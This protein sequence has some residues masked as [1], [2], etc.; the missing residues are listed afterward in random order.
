MKSKFLYIL[1]IGSIIV[2]IYLQENNLISSSIGISYIALIV[3]LFSPFILY[4]NRLETNRPIVTV[5]LEEYNGGSLATPLNLKIYNMGNTPAIDVVLYS[6]KDDIDKILNNNINNELSDN[7]YKCLSKDNI[8]PI[9]Y[10]KTNVVNAFGILTKESNTT[11][12]CDSKIK[13]NIFYKDI[14]GNNYKYYQILPIKP[15][16]SF[17]ELSWE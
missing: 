17:A 14:Y 8:I 4:T 2:I 9:I 5:S 16:K 12:H 15:T 6:N 10:S 13:I 3:S 1:T 11:F 7:V